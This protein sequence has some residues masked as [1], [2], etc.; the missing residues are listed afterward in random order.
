MRIPTGNATT[1]GKVFLPTHT[2]RASGRNLA[3][4]QLGQAWVLN[5]FAKS[6]RTLCDS[7][8]R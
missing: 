8:S 6:S 2:Q 3:P 7:V 4:L 1:S 5:S